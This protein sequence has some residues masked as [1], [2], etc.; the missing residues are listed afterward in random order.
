M[1]RGGGGTYTY[2]EDVGH[3]RHEET[4]ESSNDDGGGGELGVKG[5]VAEGGDEGGHDEVDQ[6]AAE[7]A[8]EY[9]WYTE[10]YCLQ[11]I[12]LTLFVMYIYIYIYIYECT[13]RAIPELTRAL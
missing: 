7:E 3:D 2:R 5:E 10:V 12:K 8:D 11:L 13:A 9:T 6:P 1:K 4:N